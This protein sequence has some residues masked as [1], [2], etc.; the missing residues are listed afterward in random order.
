MNAEYIFLK[1]TE[2][3][4]I[5]FWASQGYQIVN[6][7]FVD[8]GKLNIIMGKN[9]FINLSGDI[10]QELINEEGVNFYIDKNLSYGDIIIITFLSIFL[11]FGIINFMIKFF[12]PKFINFKK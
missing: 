11:I 3:E 7:E 6:A 10:T 9:L 8:K 12:I 2:L 5:N 1:N 4:T